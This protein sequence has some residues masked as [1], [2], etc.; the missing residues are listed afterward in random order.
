MRKYASAQ[1]CECASTQGSKCANTQVRKYTSAQVL[2][3]VLAPVRKCAS[4]CV[5]RKKPTCASRNF[6]MIHY[7]L[8][9]R[10]T[11]ASRQEFKYLRKLASMQVRQ[12]LSTYASVQGLAKVLTQKCACACASALVM[13]KY[14]HKCVSRHILNATLQ[15]YYS[16][17]NS[18][19]KHDPILF[20]CWARSQT[21]LQ[22]LAIKETRQCVY[23]ETDIYLYKRTKVQWRLLISK[24]IWNSEF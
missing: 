18:N 17:C 2:R 19:C 8:K 11:F 1:V 20:K 22:H 3:Q 9:W 6:L 23:W 14:L 5:R 24:I 13:C 21:V 16:S 12:C 15:H 7:K 4:T 10:S